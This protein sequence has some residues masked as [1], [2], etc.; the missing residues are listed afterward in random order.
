VL[1]DWQLGSLREPLSE[2]SLS[3]DNARACAVQ[4]AAQ[5]AAAGIA[6]GDRVFLCYGNR[7][8]FFVDLLAIWQLGA[9]AIPIDPRFT[10]FEVDSLAASFLPRA[11][12]TDRS[13]TPALESAL[14]AR[15]VRTLPLPSLQL[16]NSAAQTR[17]EM[18]LDDAALVLLT[19]GTTGEPKGVVHTHRTLRARLLCQRDQ[20]GV[21]TFARTACLLPTNFAWGLVGNSLYPWLSGQEL[22]IFPAFRADLLPKL[23]ALCDQHAVTYLPAVPA[24]W[25]M[26]LRMSAP[27]K[28]GQLRRVS[29]GTGPLSSALWRDVARWSGTDDVLTVYGITECGW[30]AWSS[31][32]DGDAVDGLVGQPYGGVVRILPIKA[33]IE[34][35]EQLAPLLPG[36]HGEVWVNT[37]AL[38]SGYH[39]REDLTR[40]VVSNGWFR[41]GDVGS[42]DAGGRLSLHGREKEM[43]NAGGVKVYPGDIDTVIQQS[44]HVLDVCAFAAPDPLH[45]EQV[46]VAVSVD[47]A[48]PDSLT[49]AHRWAAE[50]LAAYQLPRKWY[51]VPEIPKT[52]RAKVNRKQVAEL[53][54]ALPPADV[55]GS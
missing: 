8:E 42:L 47:P 3:G 23:G 6:R 19:S 46:A 35:A 32:R 30:L 24:M 5:L 33:D 20:L 48:K 31:L 36:D 16:T 28:S 15:H 49:A 18:R 43:I 55:G 11:L 40:Q 34:S 53:C 51:V 21:E 44:G 13:L 9:C 4:R 14:A 38:M 45:G 37:A 54:A 12:V 25:K 22:V 2:R 7:C 27:P 50:R 52:L 26:V 17:S 41:T 39:G 10:D 29:S 1:L